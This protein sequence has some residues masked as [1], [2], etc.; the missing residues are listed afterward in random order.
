MRVPRTFVFVDLTGFTNYTA[1]NGDDAAGHL[2]S[3]FRAAT[4]HVASS[5]GVRVAK[6]L[7]DGAML[8]ALDQREAVA[9]SLELEQRAEAE[10]APLS[11]RVGMA[12]G[13]AL[14]FEGDD[15]IGS[16]VNLAAR[17]CDA[18]G[19]RE[20]LLPSDQ[21]ESLPPG[22]T[23]RPSGAHVLRGFPEPIA[24]VTIEGHPPRTGEDDTGEVWTR[25]PFMA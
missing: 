25:T 11:L 20:V 16:A 13:L 8:V 19:P 17:L 21:L 2:L 3:R 9:M 15:Y 23:A 14:L 7:G 4:R 18:A 1:E 6:W 5:R 10:C 24:V 22:V 12:S